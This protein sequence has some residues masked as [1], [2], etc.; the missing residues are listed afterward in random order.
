MKRQETA[1]DLTSGGNI[2]DRYE[3]VWSL[4]ESDSESAADVSTAM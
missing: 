1:G 4:N 3:A 2:F